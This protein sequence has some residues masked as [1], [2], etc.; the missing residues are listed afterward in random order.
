MTRAKRHRSSVTPPRSSLSGDRDEAEVPA[1]RRRLDVDAKDPRSK[2]RHTSSP[3]PKPRKLPKLALPQRDSSLHEEEPTRPTLKSRTASEA[4]RKETLSKPHSDRDKSVPIKSEAPPTQDTAMDLD[5]T[6]E[7]EEPEQPPAKRR[8]SGSSANIATE[9][10][11]PKQMLSK[12]MAGM[13]EGR[14]NV[15]LSGIPGGRRFNRTRP[16]N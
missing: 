2:Q 14:E 6:P 7:R 15:P 4:H 1:K 5:K 13:M 8:R 16:S 11:L 3:E 10:K 9:T 12:K